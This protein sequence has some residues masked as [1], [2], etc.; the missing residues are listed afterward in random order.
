MGTRKPTPPPLCRVKTCVCSLTLA[1][2]TAN[3]DLPRPGRSNAVRVA[4]VVT[5][6]AAPGHELSR[7]AGGTELVCD[8]G[9]FRVRRHGHGASFLWANAG[10]MLGAGDQQGSGSTTA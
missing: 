3:H 1:H 7:T 8:A 9:R 6:P 10:M 4:G 2:S 5:A